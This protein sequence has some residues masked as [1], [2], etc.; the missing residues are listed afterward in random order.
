MS[1]N[2]TTLRSFLNADGKLLLCNEPFFNQFGHCTQHL[3]GKSVSEVFSSFEDGEILQ[4][5]R[6]CQLN[7]EESFTVEME[8]TCKEGCKFFRWMIYAEKQQ[9]K[10]TG[11]HLVGQFFKTE[12]AA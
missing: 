10:L 7:P 9:G 8:K 4:A 6:Y 11:I 2:Q 3:I 12:K 5:V 1:Y